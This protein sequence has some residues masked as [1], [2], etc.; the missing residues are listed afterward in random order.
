MFLS[1]PLFPPNQCCTSIAATTVS[2]RRAST[3]QHWFSGVRGGIAARMEVEVPKKSLPCENIYKFQTSQI[4]TH[5]EGAHFQLPFLHSKRTRTRWV[6]TLHWNLWFS[7]MCS[8]PLSRSQNRCPFFLAKMASHG[9]AL[10]VLF[11][12]RYVK[13]QVLQFLS[14]KAPSVSI[15][16]C[17]ERRWRDLRCICKDSLQRRLMDAQLCVPLYLFGSANR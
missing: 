2:S 13:T 5:L 14:C 1:N 15:F 12:W 3:Q 11:Q 4:S 17:T 6:Q 8:Y 9:W 10:T 16:K 7:D